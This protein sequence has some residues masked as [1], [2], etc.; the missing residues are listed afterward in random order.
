M[1]NTH[2]PLKP[3]VGHPYDGAQDYRSANPWS[4]V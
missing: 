1:D 3:F 2:K 4:K